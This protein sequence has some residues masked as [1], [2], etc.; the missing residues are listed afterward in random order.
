VLLLDFLWRAVSSMIPWPRGT[1]EIV[2]LQCFAVF[3]SMVQCGVA[4]C[5]VVQC[6]AV[7]FSVFKRQCWSVSQWHRNIKALPVKEVCCVALHLPCTHSRTHKLTLT[8][9]HACTLAQIHTHLHTHART[10]VH[11][12]T[13]TN[14]HK[15][16]HTSA[17]VQGTVCRERGWAFP[18]WGVQERLWRERWAL[19]IKVH[20]V[21]QCF[22]VWCSVL[23]CVAVSLLYCVAREAGT[24]HWVSHQVVARTRQWF[25]LE[26]TS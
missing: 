21:M 23:Q 16:T 17:H 6:L 14:T 8:Q 2:L 4:W 7:S 25:Y 1:A 19:D 3:C 12:D 24:P 20:G 18:G 10:Y 11:T 5:S 15:H 9:I 26:Y 22:A 13:H